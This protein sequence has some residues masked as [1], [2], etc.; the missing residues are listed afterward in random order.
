MFLIP[1]AIGAVWLGMTAALL[2]PDV[3]NSG[4]ILSRLVL[5]IFPVGLK[6]L[7]LISILAALMS[8]ADICIL[9]ASANGSCDIYQRY[10]N[11]NVSPKNLVSISIGLAVVI[12][13]FAMLV[14]WQM[15]DIIGILLLAFTINSAALFV[16]TIAM[17]TLKSANKAA[18]FWSITLSLAT[19]IAW[20]VASTIELAPIFSLDPLWPGLAVSITVFSTLSLVTR[21]E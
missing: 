19:V 17:V 9:T 3:E 7:M 11:P 18:A 1:L 2:Y 4:E 5:D 8:T 12:G 6:G 13:A 14:A 15:Q 21:S 16:P 20:Y 10:V